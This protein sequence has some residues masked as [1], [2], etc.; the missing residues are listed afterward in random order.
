MS[1]FSRQ[2]VIQ[3]LVDAGFAVEEAE[4]LATKAAQRPMQLSVEVP[5]GYVARFEHRRWV[6]IETT[7]SFNG[8][9]YKFYSKPTLMN[10]HEWTRISEYDGGRDKV[11][12]LPNGGETTCRLYLAATENHSE[13]L[14]AVVTTVCAPDDN[15][16]KSIGRN[17]TLGLAVK[18]LEH[19]LSVAEE[20]MANGGKEL[21]EALA[22]LEAVQQEHGHDHGLK[23]GLAA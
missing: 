1:N 12:V 15:Y 18:A 13:E 7:T 11:R 5:E 20:Y 2:Q 6:V 9:D 17:I 22:N 16:V 8:P 10:K 19:R 23:P 21:G 14:A 4:R 3:L